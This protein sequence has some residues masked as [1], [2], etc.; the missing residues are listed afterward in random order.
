MNLL[1][2]GGVAGHMSHLYDNP[3][4]TFSKMKEIFQKAFD[5]ELEGTEKTDGQN[6]FISYDVNSGRAKAARNKSNIINGGLDAEGLASKF[7]GRG[8]VEAAF[9]DAFRA[10]EKAVDQFSDEEKLEI[11]GPD[12]NIY[13][14]AE[15]QDP[16]NANVINYEYKTLNIHRAGHA[17][18]NRETGERTDKDVSQNAAKLEA[19]LNRVKSKIEKDHR[20]QMNAIRNLEKINDKTV[21]KTSIDE[22]EKAISNEGISDNQTVGEYMVARVSKAVDKLAEGLSDEV[23][24][25]VIKRVFGVEGVS[26]N[27]IKKAIPKDQKD[28]LSIIK[29]IIDSAD[30]LKKYAILPIEEIVHDFAVEVLKYFKSIFVVDNEKEVQRLRDEVEEAISEIEASGNEEAMEVL[31]KQF[32]KLKKLDNIAT[33][34]EG[35]VF[36]YDGYTYKLTGTFAPMNQIL[37]LFKYG[38]GNIPPIKKS[39][40]LDE[41]FIIREEDVFQDGPLIAVIPGGFKPPHRGHFEMVKH[42]ADVADKVIVYVSPQPRQSKD[43]KLFDAD[44]AKRI[45]ELYI[46]K[47][48]LSNVDVQL[49]SIASP[50][51]AS[52]EYVEKIAEP[53]EQVI[54]GTSTKGGDQSRFARNVQSY[55]KPGVIVLDPMEYAFDPTGEIPL[56]ATDFREAISK[57]QDIEKFLPDNVSSN[58]FYEVI[59]KQSLS[60]LLTKLIDVI[61]IEERNKKYFGKKVYDAA[62]L[63]EVPPTEEEEEELEEMS[64]MGA[65]AVQGYGAKFPGPGMKIRKNNNK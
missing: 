14:N 45:F 2:E 17:E 8:T 38:R 46:E 32:N 41:I 56:S 44:M 24:Q 54:L 48:G 11:F 28:K 23:K 22:L 19:A 49:S 31:K 5:G 26:A 50:V 4:L 20:I 35:F 13:Y 6:L 40:K 16:R 33:A 7:A 10:F 39:E 21:L 29:K 27:T 47:T 59:E 53:G 37:G 62:M 55:A 60:E 25:L 43:G 63:H 9:N 57:G 3:S 58:D 36:D 61:I 15:V 65:G 12:T 52:Y 42:Y 18:F 1:N 34:A 64:A 51:R 30:E